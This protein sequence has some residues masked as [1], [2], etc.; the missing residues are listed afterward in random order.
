MTLLELLHFLTQLTVRI[1]REF[2]GHKASV[3]T[4]A[5]GLMNSRKIGILRVMCD[6]LI[7]L[8]NELRRGIVALA[9]WVR[10]IQGGAAGLPLPPEAVVF[11]LDQRT[12]FSAVLRAMQESEANIDGFIQQLKAF[13]GQ[14]EEF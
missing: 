9:R 2:P 8:R 3:L 13:L 6:Q 7:D 12:P 14:Y 1:T 10:L 11:I 4:L 5:D